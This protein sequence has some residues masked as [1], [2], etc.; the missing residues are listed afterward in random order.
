MGKLF[1]H[2]GNYLGAGERIFAL[3]CNRSRSGIETL[4]ECKEIEEFRY[5]FATL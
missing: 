1:R 3:V 2:A 4:L 5:A